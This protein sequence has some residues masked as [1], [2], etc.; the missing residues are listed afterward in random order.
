MSDRRDEAQ[1]MFRDVFTIQVIPLEVKKE[2]SDKEKEELKK[3]IEIFFKNNNGKKDIYTL[4]KN[5]ILS[6]LIV[7]VPPVFGESL[8]KVSDWVNT[9]L[10]LTDD[11]GYKMREKL[12][13]WMN[14]IY[15]VNY[16]YDSKVGITQKGLSPQVIDSFLFI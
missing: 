14:G 12:S 11:N 4:F 13:R 6:K 2:D 7:N 10:F 1:K 8:P 3:E 5:K 15:F 9:K 16:E